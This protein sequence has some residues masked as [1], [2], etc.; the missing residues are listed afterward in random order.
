MVNLRTATRK[1]AGRLASTGRSKLNAFGRDEDGTA[2]IEFVIVAPLLIST[3]LGFAALS[4][5][6][7]LSSKVNDVGRT[8]SDI[9]SQSPEITAAQVDAA[10]LA[11]Q[12]IA[13]SQEAQ[14]MKI[15]VIGVDVN[16][17]GVAKVKW[18]RGVNSNSLPN[19]G[20]TFP[21][22]A[23]L[24]NREAFVVVSRTHLP[25][26]PSFATALIGTINFDY[27]YYFIPRISYETV[28]DDC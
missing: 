11:G 3:F 13:G 15:E 1:L 4:K 24:T 9:V 27:E 19:E 6:E 17:A 26:S 20:T 21:L 16:D 10:L 14:N 12:A 2:A 8:V 25:Y 18:S 5:G 7:N 23:E 22:P 28:C